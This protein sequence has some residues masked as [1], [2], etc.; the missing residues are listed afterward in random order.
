LGL[1]QN[2]VSPYF[3]DRYYPEAAML[4]LYSLFLLCK[5][6]EA[7]AQLEAFQAQYQP[8][9]Q[10][11]MATASLSPAQLFDAV[12]RHIEGQATDLPPMVSAAFENEDRIRD[13]IVAV[14]SA[15][16][17]MGRLRNVSAN[18]FAQVASEWVSA[19]R[20]TIIANEGGRILSRIQSMEGELSE[21]LGNS[22]V[23][24]LDLM[25]MEARLYERASFTGKLPE[26]KRR[27]K[28]KVRARGQERLW[29]WQG[30]YWA[31]EIGYYK[32]DTKPECP[33]NMT[34]GG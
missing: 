12:R 23:T 29:D 17:E 31:D 3:S 10:E 6:P 26:S 28:R 16:E 34:Q 20:E 21:M 22:D 27:V 4:R 14:T 2:H 32:I 11:L 8:Q 19:R 33:E 7:S 25:Q 1:L 30:E 18:V 15:E 5:F 9:Q 13:S 24:K